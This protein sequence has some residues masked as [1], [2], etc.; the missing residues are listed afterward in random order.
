V[1]KKCRQPKLQAAMTGPP[2]A[3][4]ILSAG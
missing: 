1:L 4:V 3:G 2:E